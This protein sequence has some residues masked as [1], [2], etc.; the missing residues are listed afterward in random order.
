M[1]AHWPIDDHQAELVQ[2]AQRRNV[3]DSAK[4]HFVSG[5]AAW[6]HDQSGALADFLQV[7][8]GVADQQQVST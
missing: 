8:H 2:D 5:A 1:L 6:L 7:E 3:E 4:K